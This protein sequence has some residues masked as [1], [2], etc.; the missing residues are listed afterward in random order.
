VNKIT[1]NLNRFGAICSSFGLLEA[2][3]D[4]LS[5]LAIRINIKKELPFYLFTDNIQHPIRICLNTSDM[6]VYCQIFREKEY[7]C[8]GNI[9]DARFIIDCGGYIGLSA[10]WFLNKYKNAHLIVVEPDPRN[11]A[12]CKKNLKFYKRRVTLINSAVWPHQTGLL[13]SRGLHRDGGYWTTQV[14]E[15]AGNQRADI[16]SV[17]MD[18]LIKEGGLNK[19]DILKVDIERAEIKLFSGNCE[20][21]LAKVKNM[22]IELHDKECE[23]IFFKAMEKFNYELS[24]SGELVICK[25]ISPKKS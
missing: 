18:S 10:I 2:F 13:I 23:A 14:L 6:D 4:L 21:W 8:L 3:V 7:D 19:V 9:S 11:F 12:I 5:R 20:A 15:V 22:A 25:N 17:E 24:R 16:N 1:K